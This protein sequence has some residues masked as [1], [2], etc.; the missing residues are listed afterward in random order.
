MTVNS[1]GA[2]KAYYV[3][4]RNDL[5][6]QR[7]FFGKLATDLQLPQA[8]ATELPL[9]V[10]AQRRTDGE[11]EFVFVQN[12]T[13]Q[14]KTVSLPASYQEMTTGETLQG[15]LELAAYG[16]RVLSRPVA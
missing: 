3:A 9:G 4:S 12:Y 8:L 6:F 10:T 11:Q 2:G 16:C 1:H 5:A 15:S 13:G 7:A 14:P